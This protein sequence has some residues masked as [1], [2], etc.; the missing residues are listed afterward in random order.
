MLSS[1]PSNCFYKCTNLYRADFGIAKSVGGG[2]FSSATSLTVLILR[3][4]GAICTLS[5]SAAL[6]NTAIK[7][8][9]GYIYVPAVLID[10]YKTATNWSAFANQFRAIED[11]PEI[12]GG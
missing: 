1:I 8:G 11:Y 2:A 12:T 5:S 6:T 9:T 7:N 10:T 3:R 4:T